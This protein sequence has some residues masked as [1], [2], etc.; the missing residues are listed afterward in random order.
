MPMPARG[1]PPRRLPAP[2]VASGAALMALGRLQEARP[3]LEEALRLNPDFTDARR[4]L[5]ILT[6]AQGKAP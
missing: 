3:H 6:Q 2:P 1:M 5:E 4:N